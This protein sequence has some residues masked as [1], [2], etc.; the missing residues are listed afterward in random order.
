MR[1]RR[2]AVRRVATCAAALALGVATAVAASGSTRWWETFRLEPQP[3]D[4]AILGVPVA[5][6]DS[7]WRLARLLGE[8]DLD[9]TQRAELARRNL[10]LLIDGDFNDDGRPDKAVVGA[11]VDRNDRRGRFVAIFTRY[12]DRWSRVYRETVEGEAGFGALSTDLRQPAGLRRITWSTC[13]GCTPVGEITWSG[14]NY[15]LIPADTASGR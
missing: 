11:Y 10:T 7:D 2:D 5:T 12:T 13:V 1:S 8:A 6:I 9:K 15:L 4:T 3:A 14:Q